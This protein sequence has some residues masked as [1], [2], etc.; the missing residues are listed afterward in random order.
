MQ[1]TQIP[2]EKEITFCVMLEE[3]WAKKKKKLKV[4]SILVM[5]S[6][7]EEIESSQARQSL[8][9]RTLR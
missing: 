7:L 2:R 8:S 1:S 9:H 4:R 6:H 3:L 5:E